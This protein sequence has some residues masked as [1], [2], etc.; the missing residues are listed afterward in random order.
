[1]VLQRFVEP[2]PL[3]QFRNP[4]KQSVRFLGQ[5]I[6]ASQGRYLHTGHHKHRISAH[7]GIH[8]LSG[9][10]SPIP[11]FKR[12]KTV[13]ALNRTASVIGKYLLYGI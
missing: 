7:T 10:R 2:W 3:F 1:M 9:I 8:A 5:V 12:A 6:C 13:H 4:F 11:A